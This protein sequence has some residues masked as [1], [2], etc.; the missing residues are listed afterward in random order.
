MSSYNS[1]YYKK[2]MKRNKVVSHILEKFLTIKE[3][4]TDSQPEKLLL[5]NQPTPSQ[6]RQ[7]LKQQANTD[8]DNLPDVLQE[9]TSSTAPS[10]S[11]TR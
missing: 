5:C 9:E 6:R 1:K 3:M 10:V 4:I 11:L 2:S 7:M 8:N